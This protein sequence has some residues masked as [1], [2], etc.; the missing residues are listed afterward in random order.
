[1]ADSALK[2]MALLIL[3]LDGMEHGMIPESFSIEA[4]STLLINYLSTAGAIITNHGG[5]LAGVGSDRITACWEQPSKGA[6]EACHCALDLLDTMPSLLGEHRLEPGALRLRIGIAVA[7]ALCI[8]GKESGMPVSL[9]YG[10]AVE[11]AKVLAQQYLSQ[12]G[13]HITVS[14]QAKTILGSHF[15]FGPPEQ[16][17]IRGQ[18][19]SLRVFRLNR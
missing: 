4:A 2:T 3:E 11:Q 15:E 9:V 1:M 18:P 12:E 16:I 6:I 8:P 14:E 10:E 17:M 13:N 5:E 7:G 19:E